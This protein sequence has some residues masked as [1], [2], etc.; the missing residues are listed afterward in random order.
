VIISND[1]VPGLLLMV[2][3]AMVVLYDGLTFRIPNWLNSVIAVI[4]ILDNL[5]HW[6]RAFWASHIG[7]AALM[8]AIGLVFFRFRW[9]GGGDVKLIGACAL[10]T[11]FERLMEFAVYSAIAGGFLAVGVILLRRYHTMVV[12][13]LPAWLRDGP[14]AVLDPDR[15]LPYGLAIAFGAMVALQPWLPLLAKAR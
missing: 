3:L 13:S 12:A 4:F 2:M 8:F 9:L 5:Q 7:A 6:D 15:G 14:L 11:G 10:W 1:A